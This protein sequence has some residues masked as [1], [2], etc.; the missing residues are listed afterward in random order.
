VTSQQARTWLVPAVGAGAALVA[1][2]TGHPSLGLAVALVAL[3]GVALLGAHGPP[4]AVDTPEAPRDHDQHPASTADEYDQRAPDTPPRFPPA[5]DQAEVRHEQDRA[6]S[7]GSEVSRCGAT[8]QSLRSDLAEADQG[9]R[10]TADEVN[11]ARNLTFQVVGQI[12]A[13]GEMSPEISGMVNVIRKIAG[14]TNLLALNATIEA[15]RAGAAGA[16]F[17]VVAHE[18]RTLAQNSQTAAE[19][20]DAIVVEIAEVT[21]ATVTV[22]ETL[23]EQVESAQNR[24]G[25]AFGILDRLPAQVGDAAD[26]LNSAGDTLAALDTG[27]AALADRLGSDND[28]EVSV[29]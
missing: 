10:S 16:G 26:L 17:A 1:A 3:A 8:L 7:A 25:D 15:A 20:I 6:S 21:E 23:S 19:K 24:F 4:P 11:G 22:A 27:L 2:F 9:L 18:V 13:L 5:A 28:V 12:H 14:Q 29:A